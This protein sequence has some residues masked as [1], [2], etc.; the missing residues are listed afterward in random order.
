[1]KKREDFRPVDLGH[2]EDKALAIVAAF[3]KFN[4]VART[5]EYRQFHLKKAESIACT[6]VADFRHYF[7]N[8]KI[9]GITP[10]GLDEKETV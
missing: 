6:L 2:L 5:P 10:Y 8:Y 1:M 7:D 4:D 3:D 9:G